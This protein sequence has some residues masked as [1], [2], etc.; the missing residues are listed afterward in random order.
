MKHDFHS[1]LKVA[2]LVVFLLGLVGALSI[3]LFQV[4]RLGLAQ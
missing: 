4:G 1:K 2:A 3:G